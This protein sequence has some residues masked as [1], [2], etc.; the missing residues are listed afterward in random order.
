MNFSK[1][2]K[3]KKKKGSND[4]GY[5]KMKFQKKIVI[6]GHGEYQIEITN[7]VNPRTLAQVPMLPSIMDSVNYEDTLNKESKP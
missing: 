2:K 1:K 5:I 3:K 7:L 4:D 6:Q